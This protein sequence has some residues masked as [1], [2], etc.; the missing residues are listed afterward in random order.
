ME[1]ELIKLAKVLSK[2]LGTLASF[3]ESI[4]ICKLNKTIP[5][6]FY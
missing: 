5:L 6:A 1:T 2:F 4:L 3:S